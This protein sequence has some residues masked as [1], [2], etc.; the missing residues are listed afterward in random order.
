[1]TRIYRVLPVAV[2][3]LGV[4]GWTTLAGAQQLERRLERTFT[5]A[6]GSLV[7]VEI[8]GGPI[9][10]E[11]GSGR[12]MRL[13]LEQRFETVSGEAEAD[14]VLRDY[15]VS[16]VQQGETV[17]LTAERHQTSNRRCGT[18]PA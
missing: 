4:G 17:T 14:Q 6:A 13:T 7:I 5:V 3:A 9:T 2:L 18:I 11:T 15:D 10:V 8:T 12:S 1:M 16:A